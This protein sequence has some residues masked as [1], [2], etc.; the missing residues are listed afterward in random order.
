MD[1]IS[2]EKIRCSKKEAKAQK[3]G[4]RLLVE[5]YQYETQE[6][7]SIWEWVRSQPVEAS[8]PRSAKLPV[9]RT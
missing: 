2:A 6:W 8:P 1:L 4:D 5:D 7:H 3:K 9:H